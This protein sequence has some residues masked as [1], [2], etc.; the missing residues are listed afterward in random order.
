MTWPWLLAGYVV[1][2]GLA[3]FWVVGVF[4][5]NKDACDRCGGCCAD[6]GQPVG[7]SGG[8]TDGWQMEDGRTVCHACCVKDTREALSRPSKA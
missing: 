1:L 6:C 4:R 5:L 8:P 2:S 7:R 3:L